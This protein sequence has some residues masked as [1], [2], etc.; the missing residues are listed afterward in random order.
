MY[1]LDGTLITGAWGQD[2]AVAG[3]AMPYLDVGT[4]IPNFPIPV[5]SK[6]SEVVVDDTVTPP[7]GAMAGLSVGDTIE[8]TLTLENKGLVALS[9]VSILDTP[10]S[11][12][13]AYVANSTTRDGMAVA[14]TPAPRRPFRS[15][16]A[17]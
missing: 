15:T 17:V 13:M 1:T 9:A 14:D 7:T 6:S 12:S 4:I 8:Y 5:L 10:P 11:A 2:P 3:P 16:R